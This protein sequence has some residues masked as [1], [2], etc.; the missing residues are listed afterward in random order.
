MKYYFKLLIALLITTIAFA[1]EKPV[2]I[3]FDVTSSNT[4]VHKSAVRHVKAMSEAYPD[5]KFEVV[6]Y[7]G[8]MDMVLKDKS[9]AA[10]EIEELTKKDNIDFVI[11][12]GTMKRHNVDASQIIT[13]VKSVPDGIIEIIEKQQEGWGYIKEGQ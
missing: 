7:S 10:K 8:A 11:C 5:S 1:Q 9:V 2:K 4:D 12:E 3:V 6:M 13:G